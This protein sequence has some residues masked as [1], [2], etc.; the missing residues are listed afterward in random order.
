MSGPRPFRFGLTGSRWGLNFLRTAARN[1]AWE[2]PLVARQRMEPLPEPF[3]HIPTTTNWRELADPTCEI[4]AVIIASPPSTHA[5]MVQYFIERRIPLII[6]K[7]L[8]LD[9]HGARRLMEAATANQ[10]IAWVDHTHLFHPAFRRIKAEVAGSKLLTMCGLAGNYGP[11]RPDTPVLWDWMPH[12]LAMWLDLAAQSPETITAHTLEQKTTGDGFGETI[13]MMAEFAG[14]MNAHIR[15]SNV[16]EHKVRL[17]A[18]KTGHA[19]YRYDGIGKSALIKLP[20][21]TPDDELLE[22]KGTEIDIE[23]RFPLDILLE[24]FVTAV[25]SGDTRNTSLHLGGQV[26]EL[27]ARVATP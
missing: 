13:E 14:G 21:D 25:Q 7:P 20:V 19:A 24:E 8:C 11:F 15:V 16:M 4:D 23:P 18:V 22:A 26:V 10:S 12:D 17:F 5:E 3:G 9:A 27:L 2:I 6:E 1:P